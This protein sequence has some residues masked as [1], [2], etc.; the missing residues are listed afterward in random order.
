MTGN[1]GAHAR[2]SRCELQLSLLVLFGFL[3]A[4]AA[5]A[6][7]PQLLSEKPPQ[8][9]TAAQF[10]AGTSTIQPSL[11]I[12]YS[13]LGDAANAAADSFSGPRSGT[14]QFGCTPSEV[15]AN[16]LRIGMPQGCV[17]FDWH[18]TA[19]RDGTITAKRDAN[20]VGFAIPVK[21]AG[22]G[23][24]RGDLAKTLKLDRKDFN[25][26][27]V[28]T[29]SGVLHPDKSFCPKLDQPVTHFAWGTP[30]QI[31][32]A[33]KT[34]IGADNGP[35]MCVGPWKLPIGA[36]LTGQINQSLAAQVDA[37]NGKIACEDVRNELK[38]AWKRWSL[39]VTLPN[40]PTF[41]ANL[42][43]KALSISSVVAD[44]QSIKVAARLDV[45]TSVSTNKPPEAPPAELPE[46]TPLNPQT[47]AGKLDLHVPLAIPYTLLAQFRSSGIVDQPVKGKG[48]TITPTK[49]EFFPSND[50]LAVGVTFRADA[51][52]KL[53]HQ[54]GTVWYTATPTVE[55]NGHL[56]KLSHIL[57]TGKTNSPLWSLA[58]PLARLPDKLSGSY[59]Y[60][61]GPLVNDAR[62]KLNEALA[63][64]KN[65]GG[66]NIK[67]AND[68]LKLGR[69]ALLPDAFVVEGLFDA[70][71][72]VAL[73]EPRS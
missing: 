10:E 47:A 45:A 71:V 9:G 56:I 21:F 14:T 61:I 63:D 28:V 11:K 15:G 2:V 44:D 3:G 30:P 62:T 13:A 52:A 5:M 60:D 23:G 65:T 32:L 43:P 20:G 19:A 26:T 51:P 46:N 53:A 70:D 50:K 69:T 68:D 73:E 35:K 22:Y 66:A 38:Q 41:Y 1:N 55:N 24:V 25:G 72:S 34:C 42:D 29:I 17:D 31:D 8:A 7:T 64:P 4:S 67:V 40:S 54:T 18:V 27:F 59:A 33:P 58:K 48:G 12:S 6:D 16:T 57:M 49:I 37:I 36:M 39:P